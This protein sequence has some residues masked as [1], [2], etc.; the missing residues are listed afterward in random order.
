MPVRARAVVKRR[1]A[2]SDNPAVLA[3]LETD[4]AALGGLSDEGV[5]DRIAELVVLDRP[6]TDDERREFKRLVKRWR[7]RRAEAAKWDRRREK[8]RKRWASF[9]ADERAEWDA[10]AIASART[11]D[12]D[13]VNGHATGEEFHYMAVV[14]QWDKR[15]RRTA[16]EQERHIAR[17]AAK[18]AERKSVAAAA[19][20]EREH[21][22]AATP[23]EP[24][25][26]PAA[27]IDEPTPRR[28]PRVKVGI[29]AEY[30]A[31][32]RRIR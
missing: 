23:D 19:K 13:L 14:F 9:T 16:K 10:R 32:G 17:R 28:R 20:P 22:A 2:A 27:S 12:R 30:D 24:V 26:F 6:F 29:V 31:W 3:E 1:P 25:A 18:D 7:R 8:A 21:V 5:R 11:Y 4:L 15:D